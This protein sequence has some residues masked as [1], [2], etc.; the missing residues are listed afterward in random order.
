MKL[1]IVKSAEIPAGIA[2]RY[3]E[4]E[5]Y[6][7]DIDVTGPA[8]IT[9]VITEHEE[10]RVLVRRIR[11]SSFSNTDSTPLRRNTFNGWGRRVTDNAK[12][13]SERRY[14]FSVRYNGERSTDVNRR[15]KTVIV[16]IT[17]AQTIG[18]RLS[19]GGKH[20][21]VPSVPQDRSSLT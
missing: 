8:R 4:F 18:S 21:R 1:D 6:L 14:C 16:L 9:M 12:T 20:D 15:K 19:N 13:M 11:Y 7:G 2:Y 5:P 17:T 3:R 10:R